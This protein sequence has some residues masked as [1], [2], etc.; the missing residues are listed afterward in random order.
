MSK[1]NK[2]VSPL[3]VICNDEENIKHLLYDCEIIK[4]NWEKVNSFLKFDINWKVIVLRFYNEINKKTLLL[5]NLKI[6]TFTTIY[7]R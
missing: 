5:N 6:I 2:D 7:I 1:L 3:C 4:P